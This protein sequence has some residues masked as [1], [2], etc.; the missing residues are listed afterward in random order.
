MTSSMFI[1]SGKTSL[2]NILAGR[3]NAA[4]SDGY[5]TLNG[6]VINKTLRRRIS[7]VTQEDIFFPNLTVEQTLKVMTSSLS[8][9]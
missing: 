9:I 6:D 3:A 1:G 8:S 4:S 5:V 2:L 7:Y